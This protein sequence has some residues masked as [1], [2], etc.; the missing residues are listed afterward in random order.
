MERVPPL[1]RHLAHVHHRLRVVG[2]DVEDG[3][4]DDAGDVGG[5]GGGARHPGVGGETDLRGWEEPRE[6][7]AA[8]K[9]DSRER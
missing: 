7:S 5:V 9:A 6:A 2:V 3:S 8:A 1:S 4:V